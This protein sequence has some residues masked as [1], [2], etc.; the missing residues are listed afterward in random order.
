MEERSIFQKGKALM[1]RGRVYIVTKMFSCKKIVC[2]FFCKMMKNIIT[3]KHMNI[4]IVLQIFIVIILG[5]IV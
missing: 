3:F 5:K 2:T 1:G 4:R